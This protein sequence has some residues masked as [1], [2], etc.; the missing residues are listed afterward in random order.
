MMSLKSANW[1]YSLSLV[2]SAL[3]A[4]NVSQTNPS[5]ISQSDFGG[6]GL[7][8]MPTARM[9]D[10]GEFS[11]NYRDNDQYRRWSVSVQPFEWLETTLRYT[12]TRTRLYSADPDFSG[13]QSQK[14]KGIDIKARLWQESRWV[15]QISAGVR[16]FTGTGLFDS[17]YF[18]ASKRIGPLD[19][20]LGMGWGN[21]AESGNISNPFCELKDSLVS[22]KQ[23]LF[24]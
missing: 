8:Q 7:L 6:V 2:S 24:R 12:D 18:A 20:T 21:M 9:A 19:F 22:T 23:R 16:D 10:V 3:F 11:A 13:D 14:D 4:A 15:P 5:S 17:E 1:L